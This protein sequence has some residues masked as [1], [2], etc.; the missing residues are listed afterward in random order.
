MDK[1]VRRR[2]PLPRHKAVAIMPPKVDA[3]HLSRMQHYEKH[4]NK[5]GEALLRAAL[6][7]LA[8]VDAVSTVNQLLETK[9]NLVDVRLDPHEASQNIESV[10][11]AEVIQ[12]LTNAA[13]LTPEQK[14]KL[15]ERFVARMVP[16]RDNIPL[17]PGPKA[18]SNL[19]AEDL[20]RLI[21]R[22]M[23]SAYGTKKA[24]GVK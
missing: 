14:A 15:T 23:K 11:R 4:R 1:S 12:I 20:E 3:R 13:H 19:R 8:A 16:T 24:I 5:V 18:T 9:F 17:A 22:D 21:Q 7:S 2:S 6:R 10:L